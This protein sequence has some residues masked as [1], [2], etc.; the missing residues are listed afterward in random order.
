[1]VLTPLSMNPDPPLHAGEKNSPEN[2]R[3]LFERRPGGERSNKNS[4]GASTSGI[5]GFRGCIWIFKKPVC[6]VSRFQGYFSASRFRPRRDLY[7]LF[8]AK[9]P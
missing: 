6:T 3:A 5:R 8:A 9:T 4:P 2:Y 7:A 1:M